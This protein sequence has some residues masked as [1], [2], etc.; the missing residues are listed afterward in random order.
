MIFATLGHVFPVWL[1]FRGGKGVATAAGALLAYHWPVGLACGV[2]WLAV[3]FTTR[4]SSL[5][6]IIACVLAP[7]YTWLVTHQAPPTAAVTL[8]VLLI[9]ERHRGNA[10]RLVRGEESRIRFETRQ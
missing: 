6:A 10:L 9:L 3:A 1:R 5:A 8:V 2:T 7:L 4:Y